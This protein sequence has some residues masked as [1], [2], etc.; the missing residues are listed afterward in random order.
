MKSSALTGAAARSRLARGC[1]TFSLLTIRGQSSLLLLDGLWH[2]PPSPGE[3]IV[4]SLDHQQHEKSPHFAEIAAILRLKR[5]SSSLSV[6]R[7][8]STE[9]D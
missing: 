7:A 5:A 9:R 1:P 8:P 6:P 2:W 3:G 4:T